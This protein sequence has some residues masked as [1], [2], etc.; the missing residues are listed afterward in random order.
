MSEAATINAQMKLTARDVERAASIVTRH[1]LPSKAQAVSVS[2]SLTN[3]IG[4]AAKEHG[5][6]VVLEYPDGG[7]ERVIMPELG[8][9]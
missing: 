4:E 5:A 2:L 8:L 7:R 9:A 3:S 6:R 1:S